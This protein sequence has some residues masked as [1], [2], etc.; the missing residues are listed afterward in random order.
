MQ[1]FSSFMARHLKRGASLKKGKREGN[2]MGNSTSNYPGSIGSSTKA[3]NNT[4]NGTAPGGANMSPEDTATDEEFALAVTQKTQRDAEAVR[5]AL[6]LSGTLT[7][8]WIIGAAGLSLAWLVLVLALAATILR[9]RLS[10]LLESTIQRELSKLRRKRALYKDETAQWLSLLLNKWWRFS[11][12]GIF[13][14]AKERLEPLLNEAKPGILGPLELRELTLGEQTPYITRVRT[15]D[16]TNDD[17]V[18]GQSGQTNLSVEADVRLECE[19][20]RMLIM[21]RLFGKG[22]GVDVDL[23]VEKLSLSGTILANLTLNSMAPF[24]HATSL[25][26]SFLEKPDVWFNVRIL[27]AVQMMEVP[28]IKTWIHAVV[29]DALASWIVDPGHLE[30]NLRAQER[31]GPKFDSVDNSISQ[32][33]L[34]VILSQNGCPAPIGDEIRW[35][36]VT[37][38]DQRRVTTPL[39]STW[40]EDVSFLVGALDNEKVSIKLKAKRLVST[41]TLAQFELALGVYNWDSSQVIETVLQQKK[42]SRNSANI[43]NI[44]A[45]LEY[46]T[47]PKLD[48]D[49]PQPELT[50]DT[51][52]HLSVPRKHSNRVQKSGVLVVYI[53]S[54]ENLNSDSS[55]CN[56]YCMLFNNRK[57]V[58]TTHYIRNT[59]SPSWES[60][61]QFLVQDY[62]QVS[63]SFVIYSWN[64][65]KSTDSDML[66]L[67]IFS[68]SQESTWVV[69]KE[70]VLSGSNNASAMTVSVL[71]YP[72]K[73]VQQVITSR[74]SS[75][76][77]PMSDDD[78]KTKR[79]SLP[80]MQQAK[81]LLSH[82]DMDPAS[83]DVSS[84]LSTGSGLMEV[85][86]IRAK[87]LVAK[88]LNGFSD[89][90]CELKVNNETKYKSSIKKKTLN[91][92]WD[93]SSI[94]GLPRNDE[95]LDIVLW[96]HDTF[97]MKDYLGKVSLTLDNI[98]RLSDGDRSHWFTLR[99]TKTGAVELKIKVLSEECETQSTYAASNISESS[100]QL[101]IEGS[102]TVSNIVRRPSMEKSKMR[103][104]LD[105]VPPPPP[106]RTVT[107]LKTNISSQSDKGSIGS[108]SSNEINGNQNSWI[109]RIIAESVTD[110]TDDTD[111]TK[112]GEQR[113]SH[114]SLTPSPDQS[115]GK[116]LPQYNSFRV[117][118]QKVKR[119][120]KLRR[121]RSE[122]NIEDKNEAKGITLSLEP[123]GGGEADATELLQGS[124]L[125]HAVSQPDMLGRIRQPSPRL[126]LRPNELKIVNGTKEKYS[127]IEGKVL[128]AQGLH[129]AHIAQLY[130]RIK[131]QICTSPEKVTSSAN[132]GKTL[133]KS[134]LLP[135]MPNPQFSIDFHIDSDN[136]PR[137][138][139]LIF[140]IRSASKELLASRRITLHELLGV[141]AA[142]DEIHTWLALNNGA[143]LEVQ[144][145]HGRELKS[146]STK[147][148]FRSWS[149]HRI[150]KI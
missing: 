128:Q 39:N 45:R 9:A 53:H 26:V 61:A 66:G 118:K 96:D 125:A 130:C 6:Y 135:A 98:R 143:S 31:P 8:A 137:Q 64:I 30:M 104:H 47:L 139:L 95:T 107:L 120:L 145:V 82:K 46:T 109:P 11:A 121:F 134:R 102:E 2:W 63:L 77:F 148:L 115:F 80:W 19:Q 29:T 133:A 49:L 87:D 51:N 73:S 3:V 28:L 86:L 100:T 92:C 21:T 110:V 23:A 65:S 140:E 142:T 126:R 101:N 69:R 43:P 1:L 119:G 25:S 12:A 5:S 149:V 40:N 50:D 99:G 4:G 37:V 52:S 38:G 44:N 41:I 15:L 105:V 54:A 17:D 81:L 83:S 68:L 36:V 24:P 84:L 79:N 62:S 67:A 136:I 18:D 14:L 35:L 147:K 60:R 74:R 108:K 93:E 150:G 48:P 94:M 117:M 131:L 132:S 97:G 113:S 20:F 42:P 116:K 71:F 129:V 10:R 58:K 22:V 112:L 111:A 78:S 76:T 90:F 56:P 88:D 89:P 146:K 141:S 91:P 75:M 123:R 124:G 27:R 57:K 7:V 59:T 85:T 34:T 55:Q 103:L 16:F 122:V 13:S 33:V 127:G 138:S 106:P 70:L 114:N 72:V 144:I 32:G